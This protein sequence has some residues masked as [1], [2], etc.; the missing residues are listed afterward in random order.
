MKSRT[1][2]KTTKPVSIDRSGWTDTPQEKAKRAAASQGGSSSNHRKRAKEDDNIYSSGMDD[3]TKRIVEEYN[4]RRRE[5]IFLSSPIHIRS[6]AL[7]RL[8]TVHNL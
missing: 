7:L 5:K 2:S 1:F 3:Q 6:L 8:L 4:V